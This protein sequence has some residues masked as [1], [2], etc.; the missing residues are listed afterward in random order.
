ME[1]WGFDAVY[2]LLTKTEENRSWSFGR[3]D[4]LNKQTS[5]ILRVLVCFFFPGVDAKVER[6]K[7]RHLFIYFSRQMRI[8][9]L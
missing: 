9:C 6:K 8:S 3:G 4:K 5:Q 2:L 1:V 7:N